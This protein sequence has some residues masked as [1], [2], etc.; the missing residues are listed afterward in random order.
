M[1]RTWDEE[2]TLVASSAAAA[3]QATAIADAEEPTMTNEEAQ[4]EGMKEAGQRRPD[5]IDG[6]RE[7]DT[8]HFYDDEPGE[9]DLCYI[10]STRR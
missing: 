6:M 2:A 7:G 1:G 8:R 3:R 10:E 9:G 5:A 4:Q